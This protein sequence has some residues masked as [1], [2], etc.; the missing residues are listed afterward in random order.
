VSLKYILVFFIIFQLAQM[1]SFKLSL[2]KHVDTW[3]SLNEKSRRTVKFY[4]KAAKIG[5]ADKDCNKE[6]GTCPT[7]SL[8]NTKNLVFTGEMK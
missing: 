1:F 6:F 3:S 5:F 8:K 7:L 4:I 2:E